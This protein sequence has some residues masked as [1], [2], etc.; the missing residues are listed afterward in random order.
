[1]AGFVTVLGGH[2]RV[3][4]SMCVDCMV[5]RCKVAFSTFKGVKRKDEGGMSFEK[6]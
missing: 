2:L 4:G 3:C 5:G 6:L 1:M